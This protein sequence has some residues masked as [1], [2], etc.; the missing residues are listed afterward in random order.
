MMQAAGFRF[1][2]PL[3]IYVVEEPVFCATSNNEISRGSKEKEKA[4]DYCKRQSN[5]NWGKVNSPGPWPHILLGKE[6]P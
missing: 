5:K 6:Y 3:H 2:S 1:V 4:A